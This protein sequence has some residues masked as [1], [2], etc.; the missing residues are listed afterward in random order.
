MKKS[1]L[2]LIVILFMA[3][4]NSKASDNKNARRAEIHS[5]TLLEEARLNEDLLNTRMMLKKDLIKKVL[6]LKRITA[7]TLKRIDKK[8]E[9][10]CSNDICNINERIRK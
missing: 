7:K 9:I 6:Q 3:A 8:L 5:E 1:I 10:E 2:T 4:C